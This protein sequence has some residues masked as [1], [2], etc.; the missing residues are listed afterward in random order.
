MEYMRVC[1]VYWATGHEAHILTGPLFATH[2][3]LLRNRKAAGL[4]RLQNKTWVPTASRSQAIILACAP[5]RQGELAAVLGRLQENVPSHNVSLVERCV[6]PRPWL[7][8]KQMLRQ[9]MRVWPRPAMYCTRVK[10]QFAR[11]GLR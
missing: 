7:V 3:V 10:E 5:C 4:Q 1:H 8:D 9:I 11:L 2:L 6:L